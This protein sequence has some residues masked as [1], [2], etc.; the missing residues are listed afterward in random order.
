MSCARG[1][2]SRRFSANDYQIRPRSFVRSLLNIISCLRGYVRGHDHFARRGRVETRS[3]TT[4]QILT[5]NL[6]IRK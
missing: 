5:L 3:L 6:F 4:R 2:I 1:G